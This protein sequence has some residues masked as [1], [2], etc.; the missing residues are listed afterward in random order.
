MECWNVGWD[1]LK[2]PKIQSILIVGCGGGF[3]FVHSL[4]IYE[5]LIHLKKEIYVGSYSFG[6]PHD[7]SAAAAPALQPIFSH[8]YHQDTPNTDPMDHSI[9]KDV[10]SPIVYRISSHCS[11]SKDYCPELGYCSYLDELY[12]SKDPSRD[13]CVLREVLYRPDIDTI[14][15]PAHHISRHRCCHCH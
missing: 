2:D 10:L 11:G 3:D 1:I 6:N 9:S 7:Y 8:S 12:P 13:L 15:F 5:D 14:L 4:L